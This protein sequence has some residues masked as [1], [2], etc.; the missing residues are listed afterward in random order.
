MLPK[1]KRMRRIV[2]APEEPF[3]K[4]MFYLGQCVVL[5]VGTVLA[6]GTISLRIT[7][8]W[9][10]LAVVA[11]TLLPFLLPMFVV[12][13]GEVA[14]IKF[15][16]LPRSTTAGEEQLQGQIISTPIA[17]PAT[18]RPGM[19]GEPS[20]VD[21][22][23]SLPIPKWPHPNALAPEE[24]KVLRTLWNRQRRFI[25]QGRKEYFGFTIGSDAI[26]YG[27]FVRGYGSLMQ[28]RLVQQAAGGMVFLT[29]SGIEYCST[30]DA[31]LDMSGDAWDRFESGG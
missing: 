11:V 4:S 23:R 22:P 13:V 9:P 10:L 1:V 21:A 3:F 12:Y 5:V 15:N 16:E 2:A 19:Q 18:E 7:L 26:G 24:K 17:A 28:R 30:N 14:G 8:T 6:I 31:L 29:K 25:A 20:S 27:E